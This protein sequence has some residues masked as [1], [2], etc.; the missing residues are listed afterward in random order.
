MTILEGKNICKRYLRKG[1]G[2][3][4][5]SDVSFALEE[6]EILG[7]VGES[8]SGKS[9]LLRQISGLETPDSGELL[10]DGNRLPHKRTKENFRTIQMIF[11]DAVGSFQP[12]RKISGSIRETVRNLSDRYEEPD[13]QTLCGMVQ[14]PL[15]LAE[16][17]P[18]DL[19]GG[20]CQRFAIARA[21]AVHPR[22][23]LCDE[24]TSA[25]DVSSQAQILR[26]IADLHR[27]KGMSVIFVSHDLAVVRSLCHRVM[28]MYGGRLVEEGTV[29][30]VIHHPREDYT[31]A[32]ISSVL[33]VRT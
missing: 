31:K 12:R 26:L 15:E 1:A 7:I 17:Y 4:A 2:V 8:G 11:Q 25:L 16:R 9:T 24:I 32:L 33:E 13:W 21:M 27:T 10:L 20:Q 22:I 19:S 5:L 30:E 28:V 29:E 3:D 14:L 18:R 6:G 23:L